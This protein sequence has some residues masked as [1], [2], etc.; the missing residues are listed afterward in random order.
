M[1][2]GTLVFLYFSLPGWFQL[3]R[4]VRFCF[5]TAFKQWPALG[6]GEES[7]QV[8]GIFLYCP[9]MKNVQLGPKQI[10]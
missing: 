2:A 4:V 7:M 5:V 8:K 1:I 6:K 9:E 10:V 3:P